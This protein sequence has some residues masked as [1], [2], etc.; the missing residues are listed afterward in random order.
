MPVRE[1]LRLALQAIFSHR[2][3]SSFTI[4][5]IL[6]S[7]AFLVTVVA[8]IQGMNAYVQ[9][10]LAGAIV[11]TNAFQVRRTPIAVGQID[12]EEWRQIQQRPRINQRD[13]EFVQR[14]LQ[15]ARA[16][17]LQSGW[18]T[19]Q[20][21][22]HWRNRTVGDVL[23]FGI[24]AP[25]QVVQDYAFAA[26]EP[27]TDIDIRERRYLVVLGWDVADKLFGEPAM[28]IDQ[29]IRLGRMPLTVKGVT[30]KK[31]T[32]LGQSWDG[33]VMLPLTTFES[34]YGRRQTL[35][36]SVKMPT[37]Q[38][39]PDAMSRAEEAM[40]VA[41]RLRPSD[42]NDFVV[43]KADALVT[44]WAN[45]T[46]VL[47]AIIPAVVGIG[48]IVG[49]IVIMNI[50]LMSVRERTREIG[51]RKSL[52]ARRIDIRRQF[53]AE[54]VTLASLGGLIGILAGWGLALLVAT[55]T[56]LPARVTL[57][58]VAIA[59][60]LGATIGVI[61]GVYPAHR[62]AKLDPIVALRYE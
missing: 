7:V 27:L 44:F 21:D 24:T 2:L 37:P 16:V 5:G 45:L 40:R 22:V 53:L 29:R 55:A 9:E 61:F 52:G 54:A 34:I 51:I 8:V 12:D 57:W 60:A 39:L 6:V 38:A 31:G 62:A 49:G 13:Y 10:R 56:P 42:P 19:P 25:Y 14:A 11:G 15:D 23:A 1:G 35:T 50:M 43:D 48:L 32:I 17:A 46:G 26:G 58:S 33:F 4:L 30:A 47:F 3:R 41:R 36:I 18:P 59:L 28:A 20:T